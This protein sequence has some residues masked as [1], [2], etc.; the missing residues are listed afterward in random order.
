MRDIQLKKEIQT[1]QSKQKYLKKLIKEGEDLSLVMPD[2]KQE[3]FKY[4]K[5]QIQGSVPVVY[6]KID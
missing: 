1:K 5:K 3:H 2:N 4:I 6:S